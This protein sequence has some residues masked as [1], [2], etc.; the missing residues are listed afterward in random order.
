FTRITFGLLPSPFLLA[1]TTHYHL[2]QCNDDAA[3]VSQIKENLYVD[4]LIITTDTVQEAIAAYRRTKAIFNDLQMN[5]REFVSNDSAVSKEM[6]DSDK[7]AEKTPKREACFKLMRN[8]TPIHRVRMVWMNLRLACERE[9]QMF[10]RDMEYHVV[11]ISKEAA[12]TSH[13]Y[14]VNQLSVAPTVQVSSRKLEF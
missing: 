8:D 13:K 1:A 5:L 10:T 4:N 9:T 2:D 11:D 7:S 14:N 12:T 6:E 3:L